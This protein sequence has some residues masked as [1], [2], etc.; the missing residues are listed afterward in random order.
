MRAHDPISEFS[1]APAPYGGEACGRSSLFA[2]LPM[3][4]CQLGTEHAEESW[5]AYDI[6]CT[7]V[8]VGRNV[9]GSQ[10]AQETGPLGIMHYRHSTHVRIQSCV[11]K[12]SVK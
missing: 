6:V 9:N 5:R 8:A 3:P 12:Q 7:R 10:T 4:C 11:S 2:T 1:V